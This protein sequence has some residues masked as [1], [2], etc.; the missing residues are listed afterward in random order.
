MLSSLFQRFKCQVPDLLTSKLLSE[1]TFYPALIKDM[2]RCGCEL[3]YRM[4]VR[5][6]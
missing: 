1:N 5:N 2:D 6:K 4:S 3:I